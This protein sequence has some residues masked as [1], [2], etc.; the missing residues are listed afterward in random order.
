MHKEICG[1]HAADKARIETLHPLD[2]SDV[3]GTE[4]L[5]TQSGKLIL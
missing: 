2:D 1:H 5:V 4:T 3:H